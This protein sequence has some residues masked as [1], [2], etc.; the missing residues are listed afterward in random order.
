MR[1]ADVHYML[2]KGRVV[3][4]GDSA[5]LSASEDVQHRYLG[6]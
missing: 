3:W 5:Q 6:V 2:E 4:T 1:V